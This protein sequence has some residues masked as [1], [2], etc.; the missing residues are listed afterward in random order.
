MTS[1]SIPLW[2]RH[3]T[4]T[5]YHQLCAVARRFHCIPHG[6]ALLVGDIPNA[7]VYEPKDE[8]KRVQRGQWSDVERIEPMPKRRYAKKPKNGRHNLNQLPA[9]AMSIDWID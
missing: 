4:P 8:P 2:A 9:F 7:I 1:T 6:V 5:R 3:I